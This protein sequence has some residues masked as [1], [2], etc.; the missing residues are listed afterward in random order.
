MQRDVTQRA[1]DDL[2]DTGL[3]NVNM[4][5]HLTTIYDHSVF[6]AFSKVVQKLI[7]HMGAFEGLLNIFCSNSALEKAFLFDIA[8][9][10]YIATDTTAVDMQT[11]ELCCDMI[12]VVIDVSS[13]YGC[14]YVALRCHYP[15]FLKIFYVLIRP[16]R[17]GS[18]GGYGGVLT[19]IS[20]GGGSQIFSEQTAST[21]KLNNNTVLYMR[22]VNR[23]LALV[24]VMREEAL[25]RQGAI[26]LVD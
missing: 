23:Y 12:D 22:G 20:A 6:E 8:S 11:Y 14:K 4:S 9:K 18:S 26:S 17:D 2:L 5:F 21:I 13:I 1:T 3:E 15:F 19:T 25:E 7:P 10:I 24:C 16:D